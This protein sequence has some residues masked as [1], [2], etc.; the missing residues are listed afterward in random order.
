VLF[1]ENLDDVFENL[2]IEGQHDFR[3]FLSNHQKTAIV[4]TSQQLSREFI[5]R[6]KRIHGD[7]VVGFLTPT[8]WEVDT[9]A[10]LE[11]IEWKAKCEKTIF[12]K[13]FG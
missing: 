5:D 9:P 13:I 7:R 3:A 12:E 1:L 4:A 8:G 11:F 6:N 2:G 10:D